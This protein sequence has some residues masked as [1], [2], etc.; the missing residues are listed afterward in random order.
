MQIQI[1]AD[2]HLGNSEARD[3]WVRSVV[4]SAMEHFADQVTRVEVHLS[5]ENAGRSGAAVLRCTME[6]R[7]NGRP[8]IAVTND[9]ASVDATVNGAVQKL[10]RATEHAIGR[11]GKHAHEPRQLPVD[12]TTGDDFVPSSAPF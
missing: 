11:A 7:V 4:D 1:N 10:T 6:A 8:P 9:A 2:H 12:D 5:D 3:E